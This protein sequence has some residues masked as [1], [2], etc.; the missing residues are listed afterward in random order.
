MLKAVRDLFREKAIQH[1]PFLRHLLD[2]KRQGGRVNRNI[3]LDIDLGLLR[4]FQALYKKS[5]RPYQR[6]R[7]EHP[8]DK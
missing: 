8:F 2:S 7:S 3:K 5:L 6:T 1:F 4:E